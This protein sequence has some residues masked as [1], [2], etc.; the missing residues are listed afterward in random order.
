MN[1]AAEN[2][3][4]IIVP[5]KKKLLGCKESST[6]ILTRLGKIVDRGKDLDV[7]TFTERDV[8]RIRCVLNECLN[9]TRVDC[10]D[11]RKINQRGVVAECGLN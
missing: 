9:D 5:D 3:V 10:N 8:G 7:E 4:R 2:G 1:R 11:N 6:L